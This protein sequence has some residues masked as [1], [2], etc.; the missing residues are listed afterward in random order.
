MWR[1][2]P[3]AEW[4]RV[5]PRTGEGRGAI[6][7]SAASVTMKPGIYRAWITVTMDGAE[8]SPVYIPV[9]LVIKD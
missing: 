9:E 2:A 1:A 4:L 5:D 3:G 7:V 6:T 8:N